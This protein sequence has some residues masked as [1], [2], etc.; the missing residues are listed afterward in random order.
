MKK[1]ELE[2][3]VRDIRRDINNYDNRIYQLANEELNSRCKK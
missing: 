2:K 1:F 3:I